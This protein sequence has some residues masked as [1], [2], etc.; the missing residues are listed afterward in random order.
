MFAYET[1]IRLSHTDAAGVIFFARL[2]DLLH[3]AYESFLEGIGQPLP[4]D[5]AGSAIVIP[6]AHASA[7]YR[8]PLRLNDRIAIE[9]SVENIGTRSFTLT[10]R[11]RR[12]GSLAAEARTVHVAIARSDGRPRALPDELARALASTSK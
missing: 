7:D 6:I 3:L 2:F 8:R 5:L 11:V 1:V 9:V 10:Y 12:G 4:D